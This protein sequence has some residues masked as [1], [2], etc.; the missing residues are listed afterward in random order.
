M[1]TPVVNFNDMKEPVNQKFVTQPGIYRGMKN[2]V[3]K[4]MP[5]T[6][7]KKDDKGKVTQKAMSAYYE[8]SMEN[9]AN[10]IL[11]DRLW[12]VNTDPSKVK[13]V[14]KVYDQ[15][16][17]AEVRDMTPEEQIQDDFK[18]WFYFLTQLGMALGNPF[19]NVKR[20]I[21]AESTW[22]NMG[23]A[24]IK[25][26]I[27]D[28]TAAEAVDIKYLCANS[29]KRKTSYVSI[30][31]ADYRNVVVFRHF[32]NKAESDLVLSKYEKEKCM[33]IKYP[34]GGRTAPSG[35]AGEIPASGFVPAGSGDAAVADNDLF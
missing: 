20:I 32:A 1:S 31:K 5:A 12:E 17:G 3:L 2:V 14:G 22:K 24:F 30:P 10:G 18:K 27:N 8:I 16:T 23:D 9:E 28:K 26:F 34:Y 33:V 15:K 11:K 25:A 35:E 7:E 29:D 4:Y 19:E 21:A 6:E 13:Y